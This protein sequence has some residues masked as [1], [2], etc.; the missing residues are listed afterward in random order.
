MSQL[1]LREMNKNLPYE[2]YLHNSE[3]KEFSSKKI[4]LNIKHVCTFGI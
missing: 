4:N 1:N 2:R 3:F